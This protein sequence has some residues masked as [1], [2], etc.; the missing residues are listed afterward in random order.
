MAEYHRFVF[1]KHA[2]K[3]IGK[4]DE[5]YQAEQQKGFDSW[6]QDDLRHL[7]RKICLSI[8]EQHNFSKIMDVGCGKGA[9]TQFLK[10]YNNHVTGLDISSTALARAKARYPDIEFIE[11]DVTNP[12]WSKMTPKRGGG[13][14]YDLIICLELLSY[15]ENWQILLQNFSEIANFTLVKLFIPEDPIGYVKDIDQLYKVFSKYYEVME[16][17]RLVNRKHYILFGRSFSQSA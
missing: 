4:F 2:R 8:L 1:D 10:K 13:E 7:D 15:V 14:R 3:F 12:N 9:F 17:C 5:M 16:D 6:Q 11:T